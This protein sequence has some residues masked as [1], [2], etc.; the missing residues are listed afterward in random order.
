MTQQCTRCVGGN[1]YQSICY[2]VNECV[3]QTRE[4]GMEQDVIYCSTVRN[5]LVW[6]KAIS[7]ECME[8]IPVHGNHPNNRQSIERNERHIKN[9]LN[10]IK[11]EEALG[12]SKSDL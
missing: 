11:E 6:L 3:P 5:S 4:N 8:M 12:E 10:E 1:A 2:E 7:I 9:F